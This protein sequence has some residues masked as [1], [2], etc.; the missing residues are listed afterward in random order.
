MIIYKKQWE[1]SAQMKIENFFENNIDY[2]K[3]TIGIIGDSVDSIELVIDMLK[4]GIKVL[5]FGSEK[6][7]SYPEAAEYISIGHEIISNKW[8]KLAGVNTIV[9]FKCTA[10]D[11]KE[12]LFNVKPFCRLFVVGAIKGSLEDFDLYSTIHYKNLELSFTFSNEN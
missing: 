12:I 8:V 6:N 9:V 1:E 10:S 3:E 11:L 4:I 5:C 2:S 7:K